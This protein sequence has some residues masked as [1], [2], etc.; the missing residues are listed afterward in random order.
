MIENT[1][2]VKFFFNQFA[3]DKFHFCTEKTNENP[4]GESTKSA[5]NLA[6][7]QALKTCAITIVCVWA[8]ILKISTFKFYRKR[9]GLSTDTSFSHQDMD[10][11]KLANES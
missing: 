4:D 10:V 2:L 9:E 11:F 6:L 1:D 3:E 7:V 5:T 8:T